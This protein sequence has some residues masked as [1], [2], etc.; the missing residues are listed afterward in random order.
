MN[1]FARALTPR[2]IEYAQQQDWVGRRVADL[3]C[4]TG[5]A[6][7]WLANHGYTI[8]AIDQ[9]GDMLEAARRALPTTGLSLEYVQRDIRTLDA[10]AGQFDLALCLDVMNE[11]GSLRDLE[12]A[13][14]AV[15]KLLDD[16]KLFIFDLHTI[17]GLSTSTARPEQVI[18]DADDLM[19]IL[20]RLYDHDRQI[21]HLRYTIFQRVNGGWRRA[22]SRRTLRGYPVQAM[23]TLLQRTGYD[24]AALMTPDFAP[25]EPGVTSAEHVIFVARK[26]GE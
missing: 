1:A 10:D 24:V 8:T 19:V 12:Q 2:L 6:T 25:H 23:A 15:A 21:L 11:Q 5:A 7:Q 14:L 3:G 26:H 20:H 9:D 4:G 13:L 17:Q 18:Y 16:G 22:E